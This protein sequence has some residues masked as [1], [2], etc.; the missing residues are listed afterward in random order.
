MSCK[1]IIRPV[2]QRLGWNFFALRDKI[3]SQ[4]DEYMFW[5]NYGLKLDTDEYNLQPVCLKGACYA[6][7]LEGG[8]TVFCI[9]CCRIQNVF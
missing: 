1:N 6:V 7:A 5:G 4:F 3:E 9:C 2:A 8:I